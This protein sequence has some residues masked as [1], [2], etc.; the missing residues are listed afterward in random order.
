MAV[1]TKRV[2]VGKRPSAEQIKN[3]E[4]WVAFLA[5]SETPYQDLTEEWYAFFE[6]QSEVSTSTGEN[7]VKLID[8]AIE[9]DKV[10]ENK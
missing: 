3:S 4:R 7:L 9:A 6:G 1:K 10:K 5:A 2:S 8:L